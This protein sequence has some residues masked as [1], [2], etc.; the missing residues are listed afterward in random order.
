M[1]EIQIDESPEE[2]LINFDTPK[3]QKPEED[4]GSEIS[5][6][7]IL[8]SSAPPRELSASSFDFDAGLDVKAEFE[9]EDDYTQSFE[10][11]KTESYSGRS[12]PQD[13]MQTQ[14]LADTLADFKP[15]ATYESGELPVSSDVVKH[16]DGR[17]KEVGY[18]YIWNRFCYF[19][20]VVW[21]FSGNIIQHTHT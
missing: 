18:H 7:P 6:E 15:V 21:S 17:I 14:A 12:T 10:D 2:P 13:L 9:D 3:H 5:E 11:E 16:K 20:S 4:A 8:P 19:Y 1:Q